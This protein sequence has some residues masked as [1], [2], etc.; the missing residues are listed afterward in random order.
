[1]ENFN[2]KA[3]SFDIR[4]SPREVHTCVT[5]VAKQH[6][7]R[8]VTLAVTLSPRGLYFLAT[9]PTLLTRFSRGTPPSLQEN[10]LTVF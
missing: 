10:S 8:R 3:T 6:I 9:A 4:Q 7:T 5:P 1:M 2:F